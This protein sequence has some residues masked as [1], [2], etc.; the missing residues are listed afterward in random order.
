MQTVRMRRQSPTD[1]D[2][3][4]PAPGYTRWARPA[5]HLAILVALGGAG[6]AGGDD[7]DTGIP[8]TDTDPPS[9]DTDT[10]TDGPSVPGPPWDLTVLG[11]G[12][13]GGN[14][15]VVQGTI[16][17][18]ELVQV[19]T[20][21]DVIEGGGFTLR[22]RDALDPDE[23]GFWVAWWIDLNP[24]DICGPGDVAFLEQI[25]PADADVQRSH[26]F[27]ADGIDPAACSGF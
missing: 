1:P 18:V 26:T 20:A 2:R 10:D 3:R 12:Y 24:N 16:A 21:Q 5:R 11:Q 8:P 7:T 14:G 6:C 15:F 19:A 13:Q 4:A 9:T 22:F 27:N 23:P 17:D 25:G